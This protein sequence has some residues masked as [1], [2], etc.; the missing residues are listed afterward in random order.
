MISVNDK[1]TIKADILVVDDTPANLE[2]LLKFLEEQQYRVRVTTRGRL[3]STA[4]R[5]MPPDLILLDIHMPEMDGYEVCRQLKSDEATKNIPVIFISALDEVFDKIKAFRVGGVDYITKPFHFEEVLARVENQLQIAR[6]Q[7]ALASQNLL[8]ARKNEELEQKHQ[9][10]I[11]S[12]K[13]AHLLFSAFSESLSGWV[14]NDRYRLESKIGKGSHGIVYRAV[15]LDSTQSVAIK[16]FQPNS[17]NVSTENVE[18]FR[19]E[20]ISA[21]LVNHANAIMVYDFG[22]AEECLP[23]LVMELLTGHTLKD[24]MQQLSLSIP[25][26]LEIVKSVCSVLIEAHQSGI[27]HRDIKPENIF[28]HHSVTGETIKVFDFSIAK[29]V[30]EATIL[31]ANNLTLTGNLLGT[32]AYLAPERL[33]N[34]PYDGR[35]DIYSLGVTLYHMLSG[36]LPFQPP[37]EDIWSLLNMHLNQSPPSLRQFNSIIPPALEKLVL[38]MLSKE[39]N[40]RPTA[41]ELLSQLQQF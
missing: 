8:L 38:N 26:S 22:V 28:L 35:A 11:K 40:E 41:T 14:L 3:V 5:L 15:Q 30:N 16:I 10:L 6:L 9:E 4:V 32:P 33:K 21:S 36:R 34:L 2:L 29:I 24:E 20:G 25:R 19:R 12:Y 18:R 39:P 27:I 37:D 7:N 23:Y 31:D 1:T 17:G 13:K